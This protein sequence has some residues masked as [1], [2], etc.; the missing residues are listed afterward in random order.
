MDFF[1]QHQSLVVLVRV[2]GQAHG[3]TPVFPDGLDRMKRKLYN[4]GV[5]ALTC[6]DGTVKYIGVGK[7][8]EQRG[9][10]HWKKFL[11]LSQTINNRV[12]RWFELIKDEGKIPI[13]KL[14]E[15]CTDFEAAKERERFWIKTYR[16]Y[17]E[18]VCNITEGGNHVPENLQS[19]GG[20]LGGTAT[21][22]IWRGTVTQREW[23]LR[24]AHNQS[25]EDKIKAAK[26][27]GGA[28]GRQ[29]SSLEGRQHQVEAGR[30]GA[31]NQSYEDKVKAAKLGAV[32]RGKMLSSP[33]GREHQK[34]AGLVGSHN[35]WHVARGI[36][37]PRCKLC[38]P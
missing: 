3:V 2:V 27:G 11:S 35:Y 12:K 26:L 1:L 8:W 25:L 38:C 19:V 9:N 10:S 14:I 5:Y 37:N 17:E 7:D 31:E 23:C 29:L 4:P 18:A 36:V 16:S 20:I 13:L 32:A 21:Q 34:Q 24:G 28:R 33:E 22:K 15:S 6:A 30:R